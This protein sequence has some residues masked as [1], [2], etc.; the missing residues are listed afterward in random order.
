MKRKII[1]FT[2]P[3]TARLLEQDFP[4]APGRNEVLVRT[5]CSTISAGTERANISGNPNVTT[6]PGVEIPFPRYGGYSSSGTVVSVGADVKK[7]VPGDRV[8]VI[9]GQHGSYNCVPENCV[10][11]LPDGVSFSDGSLCN[12]ATFPLEGMRKT[13]LEIGESALVMG[14]GILGCFAVLFCRAAGAYP[15][16][17]VDPTKSRRDYALSLGA[18]YVFDPT[19]PDF[20]DKVK[21]VTAGGKGVNVCVEV[22]GLGKGLDQALDCM[23]CFGR[24]ALLGCTRDSNFTIDYYR[25]VHAPG[26]S[27]IGA[28]TNS[29]PSHESSPGFW[30]AADD[31]RTLFGLIVGGR[32]DLDKMINERHKPEECFEVYTRLCNDRNFPLGVQFVW[33]DET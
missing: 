3:G 29:R 7:V 12:I 9:W 24:V 17:A 23:A 14:L 26:I 19:E 25:K 21:A 28:H 16:I 1:T 33:T 20:A 22:T 8:A 15:V 27:L 31:I 30:T 32:L 5:A 6:V 10:F 4:D 13:R 11:K 2:E 18:D